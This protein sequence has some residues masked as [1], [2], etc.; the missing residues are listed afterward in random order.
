MPKT[1]SY[2]LGCVV[3][4]TEKVNKSLPGWIHK[5]AWIDNVV[6]IGNYDYV[7]LDKDGEKTKVK[8][9]EIIPIHLD[10]K[11]KYI[12][13]GEIGKISQF[14]VEYNQISVVFDDE[15]SIVVS[16]D[17]IEILDTDI[18]RNY[19][20]LVDILFSQYKNNNNTYTVPKKLLHN[21]LNA[22]IKE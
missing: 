8:E 11:V 22:A 18:N 17:K 16:P 15:S 3:V 10:M 9:D 21:L 1:W 6:E 4:V 5:L 2:P 13:T 7:I 12:V 14:S 20:D 19:R